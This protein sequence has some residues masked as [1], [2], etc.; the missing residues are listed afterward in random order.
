MRGERGRVAAKGEREGG[1]E[2]E[3]GREGGRERGEGERK[4]QQFSE[5]LKYL[6]QYD[7]HFL[8][9]KKHFNT[10]KCSMI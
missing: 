8:N 1:A 6:K 4:G 10:R 7:L 3:E 2:R 9:D 5:I